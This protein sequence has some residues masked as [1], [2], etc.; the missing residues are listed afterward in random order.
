MA[1]ELPTSHPEKLAAGDTLNFKRQVENHT[2]D[3]GWTMTYYIRGN[4]TGMVQSYSNINATG[5]FIFLVDKRDT[6]DWTVGQYFFSGY[7]YKDGDRFK[8]DQGEFEVTPDFQSGTGAL[9]VRSD[10]QKALDAIVATINGSASY[11]EQSFEI[12]GKQIVR[13]TIGELLKA[14]A[15]LEDE[16]A[17]EKASLDQE[18]NGTNSTSIRIHLHDV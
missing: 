16:V 3:D 5:D 13:F 11:A 6:V 10:N 9:D 12:N 8:V 17:K 2:A 1:Y 15:Y 4:G 18:I 7:V 14:K